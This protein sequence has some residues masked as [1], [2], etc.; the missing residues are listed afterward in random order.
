L[1]RP[2]VRNRTR[3][4]PT[5]LSKTLDSRIKKGAQ[6]R[7]VVISWTYAVTALVRMRFQAA[8]A[9]VGRLEKQIS[10]PL[11]GQMGWPS[12]ECRLKGTQ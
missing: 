10:F 8:S 11:E 5:D 6:R 7:T 3:N 2:D 12:G 1:R 9:L 4:N